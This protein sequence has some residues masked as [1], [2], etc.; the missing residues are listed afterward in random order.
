[1]YIVGAFWRH[2]LLDMQ[3]NVLGKTELCN[4]YILLFYWAQQLTFLPVQTAA[5]NFKL[6]VRDHSYITSVQLWSFSDQP[7]CYVS[8]NTVLDISKN[9]HFLNP[10]PV[11][12]DVMQG[13]SLRALFIRYLLMCFMHGR[14][15]TTIYFILVFTYLFCMFTKTFFKSKVD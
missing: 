15:S 10:Q 9:S 13:W 14:A 6:Q 4:S 8:I 1:M 11:L 2:L 5:P 12:A 3:T 7:T